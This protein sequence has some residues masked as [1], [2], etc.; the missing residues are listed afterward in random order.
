M[1]E[2][3]EQLRSKLVARRADCLDR[4]EDAVVELHALHRLDAE[5]ILER[6]RAMLDRET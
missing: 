1:S 3:I 6:V 2:D 5:D 4:L